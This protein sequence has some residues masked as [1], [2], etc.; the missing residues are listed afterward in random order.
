MSALIHVPTIETP[1]LVGSTIND[2]IIQLSQLN[3]NAKVITQKIDPYCPTGTIISQTPKPGN[4]IKPNQSIFLV[5][6]K[7]PDKP[8]APDICGLNIEQV[9]NILENQGLKAKFFHIYSQYPK[10]T[11]IAQWPN[12]HEFFNQTKNNCLIVYVSGNQENI[13]ILPDFRNQQINLV[14]EKLSNKQYRI[15][16]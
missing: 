4:K 9:K 16:D 2:A 5:I 1:L 10:N 11:C 8:I 12:S 13:K 7:Q 14:K 3:L 6:T 15:Y